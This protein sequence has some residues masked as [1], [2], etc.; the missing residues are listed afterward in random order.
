MIEKKTDENL[1]RE[2]LS[3]LTFQQQ[4]KFGIF[5]LD[6]I[7][8]LYEDVDT[9]I[10]IQDMSKEVENGKAYTIFRFIYDRLKTDDSITLNEL[11]DL[12]LKSDSLILDTDEVYDSITENIL[13]K[14][15]AE[16]LY[17]LLSFLINHKVD[18]VFDC[19]RYVIDIINAQVSDYF[20]MNID[21]DD[22]KCEIFLSKLFECEYKIQLSS[23]NF[24][25]E[26]KDSELES[27]TTSTT[28]SKNPFKTI[29]NLNKFAV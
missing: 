10:N 8:D 3:G 25:L 14:I 4:K 20:Y 18:D 29:E 5:C 17:T 28:I 26:D 1:I 21:D 2:S 22:D 6:R 7:Q 24:I 12:R 27:L 23:I 19:A 13:A 16:C 9:R 11:I 15:V